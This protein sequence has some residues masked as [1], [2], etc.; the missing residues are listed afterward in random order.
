MDSTVLIS[1]LIFCLIVIVITNFF[2]STVLFTMIR[3]PSPFK[4]NNPF[5]SKKKVEEKFNGETEVPLS[6]LDNKTL[7]DILK[8][9]LGKADE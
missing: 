2:W 6:G 5:A 8:N 3:I 1:V 7:K 4:F 9:S